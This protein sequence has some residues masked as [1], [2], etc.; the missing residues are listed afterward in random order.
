[1][2]NELKEF[3]SIAASSFINFINFINLI[4]PISF[5]SLTSQPF[6]YKYNL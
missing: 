2:V 3:F 4:N 1:M 6:Y 5:I